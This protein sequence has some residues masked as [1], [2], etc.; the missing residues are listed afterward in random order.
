MLPPVVLYVERAALDDSGQLL[1]HGWAVTLTAMVTVLVFLDEERIGAAQL[2]GQRDDV[3]NAFP[4]Y[5]NARTSGFRCSSDATRSIDGVSALRVQA[6]S[7]NGFSHEIVLP[8]ERV[9]LLVL[10]Q[11]AGAPP[12]AAGSA[13]LPGFAAQQP[14]YRMVAEFHLGPGL[15]SLLATPIPTSTAIAPPSQDPRREIRFFCDALDLDAEGHVHVAGW[16]VC[17]T[18]ISAITVQL[19]GAVMGDAELGLPRDDIGDEDPAYSDG[20]LC[21]LSL[22]QGSW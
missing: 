17:A 4:A 9:H 15:S 11:A 3:G 18:G 7:L 5:P 22:R 10:P 1:V 13:A 21:R 16:A 8:V 6:V 14:T 19:D 20:A 12:Q 2:G